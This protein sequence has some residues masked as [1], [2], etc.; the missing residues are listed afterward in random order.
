MYADLYADLLADLM[1]VEV[2]DEPRADVDVVVLLSTDSSRPRLD[3]LPST[4]SEAKVVVFSP[5][6]ER[7]QVRLPGE[8]EWQEVRP[9]GLRRLIAEV[10]SGRRLMSIDGES[11]SSSRFRMTG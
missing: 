4:L 1:Q 2:I 10:L 7:G 9:F 11:A 8:N 3:L 6:T 5:H